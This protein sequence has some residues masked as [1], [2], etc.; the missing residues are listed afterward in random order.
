[1]SP[2]HSLASESCSHWGR[3]LQSAASLRWFGVPAWSI[4]ALTEVLAASQ[5]HARLAFR[6]QMD[7]V[8]DNCQ[9]PILASSAS[10]G[11]IEDQGAQNRVAQA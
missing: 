3:A 1:M 7:L 6:V 5:V 8:V 9:S 11:Y 4:L 2:L 10:V